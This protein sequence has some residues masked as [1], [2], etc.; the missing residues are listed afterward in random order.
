MSK[1]RR[2]EKK[3]APLGVKVADGLKCVCG[4]VF[5]NQ[6]LINQHFIYHL[7]LPKRTTECKYCKQQTNANNISKHMKK[8]HPEATKDDWQIVKRT[9]TDE[10]DKL[11][12]MVSN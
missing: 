10:D 5:K 3:D 8:F 2:F 1:E 6:N 4:K 9:R 7:Q 12:Q 11:D